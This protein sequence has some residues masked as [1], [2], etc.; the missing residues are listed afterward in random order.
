MGFVCIQ[1]HLLCNDVN[2][3]KV[4]NSNFFF[5]LCVGGNPA[6]L[7]LRRSCFFFLS[8][9]FIYKIWSSPSICMKF[10]LLSKSNGWE[11]CRLSGSLTFSR[12][13]TFS[14]KLRLKYLFLK[15]SACLVEPMSYILF[16]FGNIVYTTNR[17]LYPALCVS[18]FSCVY[19]SSIETSWKV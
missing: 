2:I 4:L 10:S 12:K 7:V 13:K 8:F 16:G 3:E 14:P 1:I 18:N 17:N 5:F 15:Y 6:P 11:N 9:L 19:V